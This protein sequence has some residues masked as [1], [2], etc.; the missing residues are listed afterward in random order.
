MALHTF[1]ASDGLE[2]AYYVDD[3]T[4]P[5][6]EAHTLILVHAAMGSSTRFY[7]WVPHLAGDFR[8][9]R[10]DMRGHGKT[11]VPGPDQ[12]SVERIAKDVAELADHLGAPHFHVGGSSAGSVV[13]E[14]VAIDYPD[15]V[16]S[17]G[18]FA[19]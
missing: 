12:L 13:A 11:A 5:W 18:A 2:I 14:K 15:R 9:V 17:L 1:K 3:Y 7:A 10:M 16:L 19:A 4:D 8:V 6:R